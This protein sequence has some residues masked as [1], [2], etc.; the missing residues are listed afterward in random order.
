MR[1]RYEAVDA[2]GAA[3]GGEVEAASEAEAFAQ[4]RARDLTPVQLLASTTRF[5]IFSEQINRE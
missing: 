2:Q 1:F 3:R 4:L 5:R